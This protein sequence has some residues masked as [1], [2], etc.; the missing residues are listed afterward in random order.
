MRRVLPVILTALALAGVFSLNTLQAEPK[1]KEITV[2]EAMKEHKKGGLKDKALEGK[3]TDEE[4]TKLVEVYEG[5]A[6]A[7]P[8]KGT[9]ESWKKFCDALVEA[10]KEIKAGKEGAVDKYKKAI[11]CGAC[12]KE[13]KA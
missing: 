3:L 5:M 10:A 2:K 7:K 8:P 6:K 1:A 11:D 13:H 4:K 12:H 9:D